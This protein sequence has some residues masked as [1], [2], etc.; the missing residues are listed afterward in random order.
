MTDHRSRPPGLE[1]ASIGACESALIA[2]LHAESFPEDAWS[3]ALLTEIL[4]LPGNFGFLARRGADP[5]GFALARVAADQ[6]EIL[7]IAVRPEARRHGVGRVLLGAA[8]ARAADLGAVRAY[9]EVAEDSVAA[10]AFYAAGG[11]RACGRREDYYRPEGKTPS[12]AM[13]LA[14]K[15]P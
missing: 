13:V 10:R 15:L 12:P 14:R 1:V 8:L 7:T 3:P 9:L 4:A 6:S 5:L 11:F 2:E